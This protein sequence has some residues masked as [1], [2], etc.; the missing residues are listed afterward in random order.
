MERLWLNKQQVQATGKPCLIPKQIEINGEWIWEGKWIGPPPVC[1]ILLTFTRCKQ[2]GCPVLENE[3]PAAYVYKQS[4]PSQ[5]RY[6][7]Y[8]ARYAEQINMS[9]AT[10]LELKVLAM[11]RG[12]GTR[13]IWRRSS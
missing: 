5:F 7:P 10:E 11:R 1:D 3:S 8:F 4:E 2:L 9:A 13:E 6:V 12:D